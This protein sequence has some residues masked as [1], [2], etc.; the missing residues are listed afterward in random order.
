MK[1]SC[2][3]VLC[4]LLIAAFATSASASTFL[5]YNDYV[6]NATL[7][8]ADP[9]VV[10]FT[11]TPNL[12]LP[13]EGTMVLIKLECVSGTIPTDEIT[14]I[15]S[16]AVL[17]DSDGDEYALYTWRVNGVGFDTE[18]GGFYTN[19]KQD[20]VELLF[21]MEGKEEDAVVGGKLVV[22]VSE[23]EK[24]IILLDDIPKEAAQEVK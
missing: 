21:F 2:F 11:E 15:A 8:S 19:E 5:P 22:P 6:L 7:C 24:I 14:S 17:R 20:A 4:A 12:Q 9:E 16:S 13:G 18:K 10:N 3:C 1:R 23:F